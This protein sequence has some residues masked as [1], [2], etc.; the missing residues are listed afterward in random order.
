M[1]FLQQMAV[2]DQ[3][4]QDVEWEEAAAWVEAVAWVM[5]GQADAADKK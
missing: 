4:V 5:A 1:E 2:G 3:A